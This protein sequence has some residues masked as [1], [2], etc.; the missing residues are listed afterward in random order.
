MKKILL[1]IL[2]CALATNLF[3]GKEK[4]LG[5]ELTIKEPTKISD[6]LAAPEKYENKKVLVEGR[7]LDVCKKRGCWITIASDK[8]FE[9][10][11]IKVKDGVIVFPV[12]ARGKM[13]KLEGTF[14]KVEYTMEQTIKMAEHKAEEAGKEFDPKSITEPKISWRIKALGAVIT[15]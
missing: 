15:M 11:F 13:V 9:E 12:E 1:T 14:V 3:A 8:E 4:Q 10:I 5:K 7:I 6:I 2:V